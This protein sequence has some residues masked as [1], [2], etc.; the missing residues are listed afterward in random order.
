MLVWTGEGALQE[1]MAGSLGAVGAGRQG[2]MPKTVQKQNLYYI[3][4]FHFSQ[5]HFLHCKFRFNSHFLYFLFL[6]FSGQIAG[7]LGKIVSMT[8]LVVEPQSTWDFVAAA[9][10]HW[11]EGEE[12]PVQDH[13]RFM[14]TH[15]ELILT[16]MTKNR[17]GITYWLKRNCWHEQVHWQC[18]T[19]FRLWA[20]QRIMPKVTVNWLKPNLDPRLIPKLV[21]I[22]LCKIRSLI[23][24][25]Q[26]SEC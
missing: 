8:S 9:S 17:Q 22:L 5:S 6:A 18:L 12:S 7:S 3:A 23:T 15:F 21:L 2:W 20:I 24:S 4:C 13:Y 25:N 10:L 14:W 26:C 16:V 11:E 1:L 19:G